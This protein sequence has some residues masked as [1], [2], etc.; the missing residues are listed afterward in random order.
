MLHRLKVQGEISQRSLL[1]NGATCLAKIDT[2]KAVLISRVIE[3]SFNPS[4]IEVFASPRF[5]MRFT[6]LAV[7]VD[8]EI[9]SDTDSNSDFSKQ[10]DNLVVYKS[11]CTT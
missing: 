10:S 6:S 4:V 7:A 8:I 11:H 1:I 9:E 3:D 5:L 2:G